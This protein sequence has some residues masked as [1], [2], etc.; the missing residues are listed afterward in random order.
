[1]R[2][3]VQDP[4]DA[5]EGTQQ[6]FLK[7]FEALP[8]YEHRRQPFR[9]WLFVIA[10]NQAISQLRGQGRLQPTD[11]ALLDERRERT[12]AA[13]V[14][15]D[16]LDSL[17]WITDRELLMFIERLPEPQRQVLLLRYMLDLSH[18]QIGEVLDRRPDDVRMLLS[19]AQRFLHDRLVGLGRHTEHSRPQPMVRRPAHYYLLRRRRYALMR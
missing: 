12:Q 18:A 14:S 11:P 7:V 8:R 4:H 5:E 10:R 1:M 3:V 17:D 13:D 2:V 6:V 15:P 19:R 9:A 16:A